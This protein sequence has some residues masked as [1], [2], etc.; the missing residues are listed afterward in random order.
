MMEITSLL[1]KEYK[2]FFYGIVWGLVIYYFEKDRI[3]FELIAKLLVFWAIAQFSH[4]AVVWFTL[5]DVMNESQVIV[6]TMTIATII[7]LFL[8]YISTDGHW[9]KIIEWIL[10]KIW[11]YK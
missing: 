9:E 4:N 5:V 3:G 10:R 1:A 8:E 2:Y 11:I 7:Q 6:A